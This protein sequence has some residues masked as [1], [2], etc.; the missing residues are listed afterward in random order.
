MMN[1]LFVNFSHKQKRAFRPSSVITLSLKN[2]DRS[3][4]SWVRRCVLAKA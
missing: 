1:R 2:K 4:N 3:P